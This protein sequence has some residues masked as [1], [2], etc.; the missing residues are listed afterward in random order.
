[1]RLPKGYEKYVM[2]GVESYSCNQRLNLHEPRITDFADI[3][4]EK[5]GVPSKNEVE[6]VK[7]R[8]RKLGYI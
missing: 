5:L 7:E 1:M 2:K 3:I 8:L 6:K 4:R